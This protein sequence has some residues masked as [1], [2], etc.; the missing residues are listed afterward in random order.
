[1]I[2]PGRSEQENPMLTRVA[3]VTVRYRWAVIGCW[4]VL[5]VVGGFAA[6][7]VSTRWYQSFSIPGQS[8]YQA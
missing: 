6:G 7:K 8:A 1:M 2:E 3:H 4:L 5:V